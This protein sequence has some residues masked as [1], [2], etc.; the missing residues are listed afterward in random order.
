MPSPGES[1][2]GA[3]A[4]AARRRRRRTAG[5]DAYGRAALAGAAWAWPAAAIGWRRGGFG[6]GLDAFGRS[7]QRTGGGLARCRTAGSVYLY[8]LGLFLWV[9][10]LA[11][12]GLSSCGSPLQ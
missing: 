10:A 6:R 12:L 9:L 4:L 2:R 7:L 1:V 11:G 3:L 5:L 8:N